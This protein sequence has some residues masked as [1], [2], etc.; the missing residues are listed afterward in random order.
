M[1]IRRS[2]MTTLFCGLMLAAGACDAPPLRSAAGV[3]DGQSLAGARP[4]PEPRRP[5]TSKSG[6][7]DGIDEDEVWDRQI[8]T[9]CAEGRF[10]AFFAAFARSPS[11][12]RHY[13]AQQI[14]FVRAGS[15]T[16]VRG[17]AYGGAPVTLRDFRWVTTASATRGA[18]FERVDLKIDQS[19]DNRVL[20]QWRPVEYGPPGADAEDGEILRQTGPS[21]ALLFAPTERCWELVEDRVSS[22][23]S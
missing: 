10:T 21:G 8:E 13:S 5:A 4:V 9:A 6:E 1:C 11:V 18:P 3:E 15:R 2:G 23:R 14:S 20:V 17:A 16:R 12:A 22:E 7:V 19:A